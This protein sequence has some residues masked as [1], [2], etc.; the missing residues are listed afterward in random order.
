MIAAADLRL[1]GFYL[2][3]R[4]FEIIAFE[5]SYIYSTDYK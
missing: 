1:K 3:K 4:D 2:E 5:K